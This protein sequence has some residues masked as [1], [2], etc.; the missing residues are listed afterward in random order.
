MYVPEDLVGCI[1]VGEYHADAGADQVWGAELGGMVVCVVIDPVE[2]VVFVHPDQ[3][4]YCGAERGAMHGGASPIRLGPAERQRL[5][6]GVHSVRL[7]DGP[8]IRFI[9]GFVS[10]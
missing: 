3:R 2:P 1:V 7:G 5:A 4:R 6:S 9:L 8:E 10:H